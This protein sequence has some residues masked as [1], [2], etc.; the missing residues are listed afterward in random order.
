MKTYGSEK[1]VMLIA[2]RLLALLYK[3]EAV[4]NAKIQTASLQTVTFIIS[5]LCA[6]CLI[7]FYPKFLLRINIFLDRFEILILFVY[8]TGNSFKFGNFIEY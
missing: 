1:L 6:T 2:Q 5:A 4:R 3:N 7:S 8:S